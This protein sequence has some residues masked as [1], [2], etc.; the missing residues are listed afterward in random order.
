MKNNKKVPIIVL[1][2][3]LMLLSFCTHAVAQD[4]NDIVASLC[5]P[6]TINMYNS[7]ER[8][9][10]WNTKTYLVFPAC[11]TQVTTHGRQNVIYEFYPPV[12]WSKAA[13]NFI[14][15]AVRL[16]PPAEHNRYIPALFN[17]CNRMAGN[18]KVTALIVLDAF[19]KLGT[20]CF[21]PSIVIQALPDSSSLDN[22]EANAVGRI[23]SLVDSA[24]AQNVSIDQ[25]KKEYQPQTNNC[26]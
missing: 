5:P 14:N 8:N 7:F 15:L 22:S 16:I 17:A 23:R 25:L 24:Q 1:N 10:V 20:A 4:I 18:S 2:S 3:T 19:K 12:N 26:P 13:I 6:N 11:I 9:F 21:M